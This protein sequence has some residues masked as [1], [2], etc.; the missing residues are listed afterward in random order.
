MPFP[1]SENAGVL[2]GVLQDGFF[3]RR[4]YQPDVRGVGGLGETARVSSGTEK[5]EGGKLT[6]DK[7]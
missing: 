6:E 1:K 3:D 5:N 7:G 4:E 2:E